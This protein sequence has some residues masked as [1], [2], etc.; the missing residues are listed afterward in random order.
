MHSQQNIYCDELVYEKANQT[1]AHVAVGRNQ[2][3]EN[4]VITSQD[5][6]KTLLD[7][8][9]EQNRLLNERMMLLEQTGISEKFTNVEKRFDA[10]EAKIERQRLEPLSS[11]FRSFS[12]TTCPSTNQ[13]RYSLIEPKF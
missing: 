12:D 3:L 1:N 6:T 2:L 11:S 9:T 10:L 8:L 13:S 4:C 7:A 5:E